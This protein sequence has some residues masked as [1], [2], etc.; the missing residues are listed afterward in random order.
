MRLQIFA[1]FHEFEDNG[2]NTYSLILFYDLSHAFLA[3]NFFLSYLVIPYLVPFLR[4]FVFRIGALFA[5]SRTLSVSTFSAPWLT[6]LCFYMLASS[7]VFVP[8]LC[9]FHRASHSV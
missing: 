8:V 3:Y 7:F 6:C 2:L 5:I 1:L 4:V 9:L